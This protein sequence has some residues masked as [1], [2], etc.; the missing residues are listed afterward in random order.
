MLAWRFHGESIT[1]SASD[2]DEI[3]GL[4]LRGYNFL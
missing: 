2:E 4:K 1:A 3:F